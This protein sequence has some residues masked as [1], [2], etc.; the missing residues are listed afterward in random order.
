MDFLCQKENE[1]TRFKRMEEFQNMVKRKCQK[2]RSGEIISGDPEMVCIFNKG[3][4]NQ[5]EYNLTRVFMH[6]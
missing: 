3:E 4:Y 5:C 2:S 6:E 1:I